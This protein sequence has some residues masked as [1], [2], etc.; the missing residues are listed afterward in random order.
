MKLKRMLGAGSQPERSLTRGNTELLERFTPNTVSLWAALTTEKG[1]NGALSQEEI[2]NG[3]VLAREVDHRVVARLPHLK[4]KA[5][6]HHRGGALRPAGGRTQGGDVCTVY[7]DRHY[8]TFDG[9]EYD[10][11]S[12]CQVYLMKVMTPLIYFLLVLHHG[13]CY[14]P[15]NCPCVWLGLEYLPGEAV[16]TPC[17]KCYLSCPAVCTVYRRPHYHTF[18]GLEYDYHSDC[19]VYL[20]KMQPGMQGVFGGQVRF[21]IR[22]RQ[23]GSQATPPRCSPQLWYTFPSGHSSVS[24]EIDTP[25]VAVVLHA[26]AD[27]RLQQRE[28]GGR[29]VVNTRALSDGDARAIL[30]NEAFKGKVVEK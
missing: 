20:M 27:A 29:P 16:D 11:H 25:P 4:V 18:D 2:E 17:Y 22:F 26:E 7:S 3:Q 5:T 15:E 21:N 8:H 10:Y 1:P 14:Y 28:H 30:Q 13:E 24:L 12:D 19:Q 23:V 6:A 9:L